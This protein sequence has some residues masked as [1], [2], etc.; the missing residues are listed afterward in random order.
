MKITSVF[1]FLL[2]NFLGCVTYSFSQCGGAAFSLDTYYASNNGQRGCMFDI[3]ASAQPITIICFDANLYAG[4]TAN[5]EIYYRAG[6]YL[7]FENNAAAWTFIGG[8]TGLTSAGNNLPTTIP[9]PIM[10][11]IPAGATYS[12][13]ITNDFGA[14]TSYTDGVAGNTVLGSDANLSITGG[15]GKSYP[16]G[17]TFTYRE[18]NGTVNYTIGSVLDV[19][20]TTFEANSKE[21]DVELTWQTAS[22]HNNDYFTLERSYDAKNWTTITTVDGMGTTNEVTDYSYLD[23]NIFENVVYYRLSQ[24]DF[25]GTSSDYTVRAVKLTYEFATTDL[26]IGPNPTNDFAH[27]I[28]SPDE[29]GDVVISNLMGQSVTANY[30]LTSNGIT[31]DVRDLEAGIYI[32]KV[33]DHSALLEVMD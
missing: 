14:G 21:R 23:E 4:T 1:G 24:T 17:L 19:S 33:K 12:F 3:T 2:L 32:V 25:D 26:P 16:F 13:Y 5:Y 20:L 10:V 29:M 15:I 27:I 8:T 18:F 7:G 28:L 6:A 11:T 30:A 9:I 31:L 22:E